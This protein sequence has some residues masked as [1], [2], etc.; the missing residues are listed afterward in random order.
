MEETIWM[1]KTIALEKRWKGMGR[2][3]KNQDRGVG[4]HCGEK[5]VG[6][7]CG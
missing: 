5:G 3:W 7:V 6:W 1:T 2:W 4:R